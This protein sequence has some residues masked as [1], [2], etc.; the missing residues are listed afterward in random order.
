MRSMHVILRVCVRL[1]ELSVKGYKIKV[2]ELDDGIG[3]V[4]DC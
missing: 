3:L 4:T 1:E 2:E